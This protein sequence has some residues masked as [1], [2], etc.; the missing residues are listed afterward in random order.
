MV[1]QGLAVRRRDSYLIAVRNYQ[2]KNIPPVSKSADYPRVKFVVENLLAALWRMVL[3]DG[4]WMYLRTTPMGSSLQDFARIAD[5][6]IIYRI[7]RGGLMLLSG[8]FVMDAF[9]R[10][11]AAVMV[12]FGWYSPV[13]WPPLLG[14]KRDMYT[15]RRFWS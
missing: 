14:R 12:G 4:Y 10:F 1:W 5:A 15:V 2:V 7:V 9:Y 6:G 3:V 13:D 8:R 11:A